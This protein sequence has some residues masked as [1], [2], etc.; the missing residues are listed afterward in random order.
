[1]RILVTGA[2][3]AI[4]AAL[5][6][7]LRGGGVFNA[8]GLMEI[9]HSTITNNSTPFMNAGNGLASQAAAATLTAMPKPPTAPVIVLVDA[10]ALACAA[11]TRV[12]P[13]CI[14]SYP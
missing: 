7:G 9:R 1:M 5:T 12:T 14:R 4:G 8:D 3:G 10:I 6:L 2:S 11:V 13:L